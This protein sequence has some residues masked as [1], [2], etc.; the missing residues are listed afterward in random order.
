M[1]DDST[2]RTFDIEKYGENK[3]Y[4]EIKKDSVTGLDGKIIVLEQSKE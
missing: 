2:H 4:L 1:E 3:I